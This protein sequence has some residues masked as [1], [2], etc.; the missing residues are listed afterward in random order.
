MRV[1]LVVAILLLAAAH[2]VAPAQTVRPTYSQGTPSRDGTGKFYMGREIAQVMGH[3]G[4]SWLERPERKREEK[5]D[6]LISALGLKPGQVAADLGAG[7]GYFTR[8]IAR[9]VGETGVVY[10]VD[11]QPEMLELLE[12]NMEAR[13]LKNV[14]PLL[15]SE[16]DPNLPAS[17]LDLALMVDVYHEFSY[18]YEMVR[19]I[20]RALKPGGRLVF[21]EYRMEDPEVPIKRL[22]K[23]TEEQVRR[24]ASVHPLEWVETRGELPRQHIVVF[25][26]TLLAR[27]IHK[28]SAAA[29][30]S[31]ALAAF[32]LLG[33]LDRV[34]TMPAVPSEVKPCQRGACGPS[35]RKLMNFPGYS[36]VAGRPWEAW[37]C[38]AALRFPACQTL[39]RPESGAASRGPVTSSPASR[40][41]GFQ[42]SGLEYSV[43]AN[44]PPYRA[45]LN[46][47]RNVPNG[48]PRHWGRNPIRSTCPFPTRTSKAAA[49]PR[50]PK[51]LQLG[52]LIRLSMA[53]SVHLLS[54]PLN[55][56]LAILALDGGPGPCESTGPHL[57]TGERLALESACVAWHEDSTAQ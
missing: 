35:L 50:A 19:A 25:K 38:F 39:Q 56:H 18:P 14:R 1:R 10:G 16:T 36:S 8:R 17:S 52:S 34:T 3:Q 32:P 41:G 22:H 40:A 7:T 30:P 27:K 54:R 21:V 31:S 11:I 53:D 33:L 48:W 9:K 12:E 55:C 4:A 2:L 24:E 42:K 13:G 15:G 6:R 44:S 23:M 46:R 20:A 57:R 5:P 45:A 37:C 28:F 26:K 43:A 49:S 29:P 51:H 47:I